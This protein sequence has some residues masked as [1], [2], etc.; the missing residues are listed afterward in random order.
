MIFDKEKHP[1]EEIFKALNPLLAEW[2]KAKFGRFTEP[3]RYAIM[4]I[5]RRENTLISAETGTGKTLSAFAAILSYLITLSERNEL[6]DK[7]YCVYVSPLRALNNDIQ[8]NLLAPLEEIQ[9][10]ASKK[11]KR[12]NI[13][14]DVRTG[15][16]TQSQRSKQLKK[17]PH[18]LITTPESLAIILSAP[19]FRNHLKNVEWFIVDEIHAL[20]SNK[21]GVHLSISAERLQALS[22]GLTRIGLSATIAPLEEVAKFLVGFEDSDKKIL[23]NC[24]IVDVSFLKKLDLKVLCPLS[25]L[26]YTTQK[27][28]HNALY[29]LIHELVKAHKTTLIFTNTRSATERVVHNLK[30][31]FPEFYVGNIEAHHSS[32][33]REHRLRVEKRLKNGELRCIVSSTSLELGIDIGYIDLVILLGS[34]KSVARAMQRIGRSGHKLHDTIKGRII[35]LDRDDLV[36]CAVLAKCAYEKKIDKVDIPRNCLDVLAQ[37]IYGMVIDQKMHI[38]ELYN[39]IR[40]SYC[41]AGLSWS[42]FKSIIEYLSGKYVELEARHIYAKIWYDE[43]TGLIGRRSRL[44]R[45]LYMTNV[46]TIPD[47]AKVKVKLGNQLIGYLD[48]IFLERLQKGDVFVLGGQS[49]EFKYSRGMTAYV[50]SAEKRPPT[51][52]SWISEMLPLSFELAL[53]IGRFRA[54]MEEKFRFN[55]SKNEIIEFIM[56]YLK[57]VDA[58]SALAIYNYFREQFLYAEIPNNRKILV[59]EFRDDE[60][61]HLIFHTL[62]GRRTNDALSRA[63]AYVLGKISRCDISITLNDNGFMLSAKKALNLDAL[64]R[65]VNTENFRSILE[66]AIENTEIFKRRFRHCAVRSLMILRH[67]HGK[68]KTVAR[69]QSSSFLLLRA[70]QRIDPNFCILKETKREVLED[71]FDIK[72]ALKIISGLQRGEIKIVK[73][74]L[75]MPSP[76]AFNLV[77]QGISDIL[78]IEGRLAFIQRMH[79][80][81]MEKIAAK[82]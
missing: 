81:L 63:F 42:D 33:S 9:K 76:F 37:Q 69:Q 32:L 56:D 72:N 82:I 8:R 27:E 23:R 17:P 66:N 73:K 14:I 21:R 12:I 40:K 50:V 58:N 48:E 26:I 16:T 1:D 68:T 64:F 70:L 75:P 35:V 10:L 45:V 38:R 49:Y 67:Y 44:A 34:P 24:K 46:G 15:D 62:F 3:Q 71:A 55:R 20:A 43:D 5:L 6:E 13:R 28:I 77:A 47:E 54:L 61:V 2:F 74:Q 18:I 31:M 80:K 41:Y 4:N 7:V 11:N 78:R 79:Q 53:E 19:K 29:S 36:E 65:H 59:E 39:L 30:E 60:N 51:V 25:D 22:P 57:V 52:P